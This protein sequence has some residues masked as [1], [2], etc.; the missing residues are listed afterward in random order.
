MKYNFFYTKE[1]QQTADTK[2]N[3]T[4]KQHRRPKKTFG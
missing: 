4:N 2:L 1:Q 3:Q